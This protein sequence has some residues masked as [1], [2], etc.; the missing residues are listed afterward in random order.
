MR[1]TNEFAL[2]EKKQ[3]AHPRCFEVLELKTCSTSCG[4]TW[5]PPGRIIMTAI[6]YFACLL[7]MQQSI[8]S[9]G[10]YVFL[11]INLPRTKYCMKNVTTWAHLPT[12]S[13]VPALYSFAPITKVPIWA[14]LDTFSKCEL[15]WLHDERRKGVLLP[16]SFQ[17]RL[18]AFLDA[19]ED[20]CEQGLNDIHNLH[21]HSHGGVLLYTRAIFPNL[22]F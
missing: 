19:L 3:E 11:E 16:H 2:V 5:S 15:H 12:I 20:L 18:I 9:I 8:A 7:R 17:L 4:P 21:K 10:R 13:N 1:A 22:S 14:Y 6:A